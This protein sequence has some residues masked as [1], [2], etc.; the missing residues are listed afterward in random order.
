ML[1]VLV[2]LLTVVAAVSRSS[3]SGSELADGDKTLVVC[4]ELLL[5]VGTVW[6]LLVIID[7]VDV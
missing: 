6:M 3:V 4:G 1:P 5:I 2:A 7:C